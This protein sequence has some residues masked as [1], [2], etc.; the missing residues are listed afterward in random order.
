VFPGEYLAT[1]GVFDGVHRGHRAILD[2]MLEAGA[3][4]GLPCVVATFHPRPVRV[5]VPDAPADELTPLRRKLRLLA[6]IG[7]TRV[8]ALRFSRA[9]AEIPPERFLVEVLGAGRGLR[10]LWVGHDFR[11]G[12]DRQGD[13]DLIRHAAPRHGYEPHRSEAVAH[14]GRIVSS[15]EVRRLLR[16]GD[17]ETAASLLGRL[18]D[19][20]GIVVSG[21]GQGAKV[22]VA[23]ANLRL[24]PEQ[25]LPAPGVYAGVAEWDGAEHRA[26]MNL[27][28]R[29]TLTGG[30]DLV[31]EVHVLDWHG[32]LRGRRML[33][34]MGTRLREERKFPGLKELQDQVA[35]DIERARATPLRDPM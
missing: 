10:G 35:R 29:P 30:A 7:I 18:P 28:R 25:F 22:L 11:F 13:W 1:V 33:F 34:R 9:F 5:F 32:D 16:E 31:P 6:E 4:S 8:L 23:T 26:V 17:V 19:I 21:R 2:S 3:R 15:S 27:G 20:E 12:K 24:A 14:E